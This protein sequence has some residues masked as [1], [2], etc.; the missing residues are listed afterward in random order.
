MC[1]SRYRVANGER[2][3]VTQDFSLK[4]N[5]VKAS[6]DHVTA[7]KTQIK[8]FAERQNLAKPSTAQRKTTSGASASSLS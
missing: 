6:Q 3:G 8:F 2:P 1:I 5:A 4:R 7:E